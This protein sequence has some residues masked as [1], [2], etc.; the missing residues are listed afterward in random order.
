MS[1]A[2]KKLINGLMFH[3]TYKIPIWL[4]SCS[5]KVLQKKVGEEQVY[6]TPTLISIQVFDFSIHFL[7]WIQDA[8]KV[9][10]I[11]FTLVTT[12]CFFL[13]FV[14]RLNLWFDLIKMD[15]LKS[16]FVMSRKFYNMFKFYTFFCP[17]EFNSVGRDNA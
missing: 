9:C 11:N 3:K 7:D 2:F 17:C 8:C 10:K 13:Y 15:E 16:T 4:R 1:I 12:R 6:G 5:M 14:S